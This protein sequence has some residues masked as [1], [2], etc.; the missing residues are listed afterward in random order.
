VPIDSLIAELRARNFGQTPPPELHWPV[1]PDTLLVKTVIPGSPAQRAGIRPGDL[2][3]KI[4]GQP[5][6][7]LSSGRYQQIFSTRTANEAMI[8]MNLAEPDMQVP[9]GPARLEVRRAGA[10]SPFDVKLQPN[11][12]APES[13]FGARRNLDESWNYIIDP[14]AKFGYIRLSLIS[15]QSEERFRAA[16]TSLQQQEARGL[17]LDLRW[18]PGGYLKEAKGIALSILPPDRVVSR[19][20]YRAS[21]DATEDVPNVPAQPV[22]DLPIVVLINSETKGG[23][24]LIAAALQDHRRAIVAGERTFGKGSI[25]STL[26]NV[27]ISSQNYKLTTGMFIRPNGKPL[28]RFRNSS[29]ND[30]WGVRPDRGRWLPMSPDM[31]QQ[32]K[33]QWTL[34]TLRP[35][36]SREAI[37]TDDPE[38]DPQLRA[39]LLILQEK[40]ND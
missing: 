2:V 15:L 4:D 7:Q 1:I 39:A 38:T 13:V 17:V 30:N 26:M 34:Q 23:G 14:V 21:R 18:C 33:D 5:C 31:T 40:A 25:Q 9:R 19:E 8:V 28:Q 27:A 20:V 3:T 11:D 36:H 35:G 6:S 22:T 29:S 32:L 24:E 12:F 10:E 37:P 16:L